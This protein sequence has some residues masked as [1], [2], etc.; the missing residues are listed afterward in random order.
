PEVRSA[1]SYYLASIRDGSWESAMPERASTRMWQDMAQFLAI[2][3]IF[4]LIAAFLIWIVRTIV[5]YRR[6]NRMSKIHT[7]VNNKLLDRFSNNEDLLAYIQTPAGRKFIESAPLPMD[8]PE[9]PVGA[10]LSR[11]LWSVQIGVVFM[12]GGLGLL[13]L[14]NRIIDEIG[15]PF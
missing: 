11:I 6:W 15:Q 14:S 13:Y 4:A 9:R 1:P 10:P 3:T 7:E 2:I 12:A 8:A 5:E